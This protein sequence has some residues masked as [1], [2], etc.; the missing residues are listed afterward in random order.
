LWCMWGATWH[1]PHWV[2]EHTQFFGHT[3]PW[4]ALAGRLSH[5]IITQHDQRPG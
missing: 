1:L 5:H 3:T 2:L 4:T